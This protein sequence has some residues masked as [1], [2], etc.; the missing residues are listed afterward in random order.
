MN[1]G[2]LGLGDLSDHHREAIN[3]CCSKV[4]A[5]CTENPYSVNW[6]KY[7]EIT[8]HLNI[9]SLIED[10]DVEGIISCLP[11]DVTHQYLNLLL[12]CNKPVLI[13]KPIALSLGQIPDGDYPDKVVGYNRRFYESVSAIK[14]RLSAGGLKSVYISTSEYLG[15]HISKHGDKIAD[16]ILEY[17]ISHVFDLLIYLFGDI[18]LAFKNI[19]SSHKLMCYRD[20]KGCPITLAIH[21]NIPSNTSFEF[22][23]DDKSRWVLSPIEKL[24]IYLG[25]SVNEDDVIREY[26]PIKIDEVNSIRRHKP[27]FINQMKCFLSGDYR[28]ASNIDDSR[29][30]L[31]MIRDIK[32][33]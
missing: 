24:T 17:S 21:Y 14:K 13:E 3:K 20:S 25:M 8:K 19:D 6:Y 33:E 1:I 22:C 11:W 7:R 9:E 23:F 10:P 18:E 4:V 32:Y 27:G 15:R 31:K 29:K 2:L 16:Y 30:I 5:A 28:A 12:N 26:S